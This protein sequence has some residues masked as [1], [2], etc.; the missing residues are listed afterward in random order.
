M[1]L[2]NF[3]Q[4]QSRL[5]KKFGKNLN[6]KFNKITGL[7][8]EVTEQIDLRQPKTVLNFALDMIKPYL[9]TL[10][11]RISKL[12]EEQIEVVLPEKFKYMDVNQELD[13]GAVC[14]AAVFAFRQLWLRN[15]P[16]GHFEI[17]IQKIQFERFRDLASDLF[18]R[19]ELG[20][21]NREAIFADLSDRKKAQTDMI[22][23]IYDQKEQ[24]VGQVNILAEL[25]LV[26]AIEWK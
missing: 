20:T 7:M 13:E 24:L 8:E 22:V 5:Q 6:K 16:K 25:N 17:H 12:S 15:S 4:I 21:L 1:R 2:R 9:Q 19:L 10:G 26:E 18:L 23:H 3:Q 11:L 14:S